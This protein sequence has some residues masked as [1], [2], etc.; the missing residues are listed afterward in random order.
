MELF[1]QVIIN[2]CASQNNSVSDSFCVSGGPHIYYK[3][4]LVVAHV[5]PDRDANLPLQL[6]FK[7]RAHSE[8]SATEGGARGRV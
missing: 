7:L 4:E 6:E 2:S 8:H 1:S 5:L 3:G